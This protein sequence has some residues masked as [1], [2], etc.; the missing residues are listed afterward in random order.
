LSRKSS[1]DITI[2]R[3]TNEQPKEKTTSADA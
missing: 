3:E 1:D 2:T